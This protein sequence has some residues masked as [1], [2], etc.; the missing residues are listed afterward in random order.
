MYNI[1][2]LKKIQFGKF[3]CLCLYVCENLISTYYI[4]V[5]GAPVIMSQPHFL[6]ADKEMVQ[7][8]VIG[9]VPDPEQHGT[10]LDVEPV[11]F[12]AIL[13]ITLIKKN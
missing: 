11:S 13:H 8:R 1:H 9:L 10:I 2:G 6:A 12:L 4:P 5:P 3:R 7:D